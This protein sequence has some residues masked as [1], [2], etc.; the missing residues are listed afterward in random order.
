MNF[1]TVEFLFFFLPATLAVFYVVPLRCRL[2]VLLAASLIFY[3][4]SGLVPLGLLL[5][6]IA[7]GYLLSN[8]A[9]RLPK[10]LL[11]TLCVSFPVLV[12]WLFKYLGFSLDIVGAHEGARDVFSIFLVVLIPAGISFYTFQTLAYCIDVADG[13]IEPERNPIKFGAFITYFPQLIAGPILRY[14]EI[15]DQLTRISSERQVRPDLAGGLKFLAFG[16]FAKTF[17]AD[18]LLLLQE[19]YKFD[20]PTGSF[21]ALY[22]VFAYSFVIYYDF[23]AYSIMAIGLARL[24]GIELPRNFREPYVSFSPKEFW[25]NWH[26]TLSYWIRDY[27]YIRLGGNRRYV[28]NITFAF[29]VTGLWHGAGLNFLAWGLYH[30]ALVIAYHLARPMWDRLPRPVGIALTFVLVSLG[31]PLFYLD[32]GGWLTLLIEVFSFDFAGNEIY[33]LRHWI[34]LA[35][36][37][38]WTFLARERWWL[39]NERPRMVFDWAPVQAIAMFVAV[40][41]FSFSREFIY[42]RF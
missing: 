32:V 29:L 35:M 38:G 22:S 30:A 20:A 11:I 14:S 26:I 5:V 24:F 9:R 36:I 33:R 7:W 16:L 2:G 21:D 27:L 23:W 12:L 34:F 1:N 18:I 10:N 25:R 28:A 15:R 31:W 8:Y 6:T 42:F 41:L 3:G 4:A 19:R 37:A 40:L 39:F 13:T 17:G